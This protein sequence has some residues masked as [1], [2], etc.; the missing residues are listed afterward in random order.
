MAKFYPGAETLDTSGTTY[1]AGA[2]G[3]GRT[4]RQG[5]VRD[6]LA[7]PGDWW[8]RGNSPGGR[9]FLP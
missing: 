9:G 8:R 4:S 3:D 1:E 2:S 7:K 5:G 6:I